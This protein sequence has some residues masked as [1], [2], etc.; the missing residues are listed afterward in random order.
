MKT[1]GLSK[2]ARMAVAALPLVLGATAEASLLVGSTAAPLIVAGALPDTP[3]AHVDPNTAASPFSGVVSINIRYNNAAGVPQSFICSGTL[4]SAR[5]VVTAGH[6][7]DT[8]GNG[9]VID[10]TKAGSDVRAVFN[11]GAGAGSAVITADKVSMNPDYQGFGVCPAA[12]GPNPFCVND[13]VA[14]IHL[15]QDAPA[16]AKIYRTYAGEIASGQLIT[17]VGYGISGDG[18][19]GYTIGPDFRVKR[20]GQNYIDLFDGDDENGFGA[21]H[22]VWYADF[23]GGGQNFNCTYFAVCSPSLPNDQESTIGGGDSGGSTFVRIGDEYVLVGNNT[24]SQTWNIN[25]VDQV[26]G[27]F[28]TSFG[29]MLLNPYMNFL[30]FATNGAIEQFVPEPGSLALVGIAA[31]GMLGARRRRRA[32]AA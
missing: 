5:D 13:D 10:L 17:M 20:S 23:D 16:S 18:I 2:F 21:P 7:V 32:A 15:N 31:L 14:V 19:N 26:P 4:V 9:Q 11:A 24:F 27:T 1:K 25:G 30:E 22:E 6:C 3:A 12:L 28:G 29:G 8:N